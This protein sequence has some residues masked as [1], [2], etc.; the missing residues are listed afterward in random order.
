MQEYFTGCAVGAGVILPWAIV[1]FVLLRIWRKAYDKAVIQ[2]SG[3]IMAME[4]ECDT[5]NGRL[6]A[7]LHASASKEVDLAILRR[8][9][10]ELTEA[11]EI[12]TGMKQSMNSIEDAA[13]AIAG[14]QHMFML[15]LGDKDRISPMEIETSRFVR[16]RF[17]PDWF[18]AV[19]KPQA[20]VTQSCETRSYDLKRVSLS[21][22]IAVECPP[23]LVARRFAEMVESFILTEYRKQSILLQEVRDGQR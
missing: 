12:L 17:S 18:A 13:Y 9:T 22:D 21:M 19:R 20:S 1:F 11:V 8:K 23:E 4:D 5:L 16:Q 10:A 2:H 6:D 7:A 14:K 15:G 3:K